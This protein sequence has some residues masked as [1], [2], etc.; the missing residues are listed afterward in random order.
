MLA[1][2]D[3]GAAWSV[4]DAEVAEEMSLLGGDG[5]PMWISTRLGEY[6]GRLQRTRIDIVADE[7]DSLSVDA[8]VWVSA[9]WRRGTFLGYGG[10]LERIRFAIDPSEN[11]F[12]FGQM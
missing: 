9:D 2:L 7:G 11:A 6:D 5:E 12:Y 1:Q 4:L 10:L 8:T 3:T